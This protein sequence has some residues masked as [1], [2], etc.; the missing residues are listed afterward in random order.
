MVRLSRKNAEIELKEPI[1]ILANLKM[2]L[3]NVT[4]ELAAKDFFGK[5][6]T[7]PTDNGNRQ[8]VQFTSV[9]PEVDGYFK[10]HLQYWEKQN[11]CT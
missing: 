3:E 6:I 11:A 1:V 8:L 5:I 10:A 9:P 4:G 7:P 2:N